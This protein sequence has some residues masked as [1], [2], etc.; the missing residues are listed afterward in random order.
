ML[1]NHDC[2]ILAIA[3]EN[4]GEGLCQGSI[5]IVRN[6]ASGAPEITVPLF[7]WMRLNSMMITFACP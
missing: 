7:L 3:T 4:G 2:S 5:T 1:P 6:L